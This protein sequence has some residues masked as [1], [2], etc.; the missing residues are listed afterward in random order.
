MKDVP[1]PLPAIGEAFAGGFFAGTFL[2]DG[3][4]HA[5]IVA[6][7][8]EGET[9]AKWRTAGPDATAPRSLRDGLA[10]SDAV[11]DD[12]H[13]AVKFCRELRIGGFDDWYLP[14]RHEAALLAETLMPSAI[15]VPEQTAAPAFQEGGP[16][17]FERRAYWTSTEWDSGYAWC[18][19][20]LNGGQSTNVKD[21]SFRVR[22]VRKYPL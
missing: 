13:P 8:A 6:P 9:E 10:N 19:Y 12:D 14:S 2:L 20:F 15:C 4:I 1:A 3:R 18:Q 7:K 5:L 11:N 17:A 16:E 21:W 22:A